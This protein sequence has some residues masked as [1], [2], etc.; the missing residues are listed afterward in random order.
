M[1][2]RSNKDV[3]VG[4]ECQTKKGNALNTINPMEHG[5]VTSW[6]DM[7]HVWHHTFYNELRVDPMEHG[8]LLTEKTMNPKANREKTIQLM[9]ER[10]QVPTTCIMIDAL[11]A[12]YASGR[13]TG[14]AL[15][16]GKSVTHAVPVFEGYALQHAIQRLLVGGDQVE[17]HM[18]RLLFD[19]GGY[20]F[21]T[22]YKAQNYGSLRNIKETLTYVAANFE[23]EAPNPLSYE[24][25]D[26]NTVKD[27]GKERFHCPEVLLDPNA[28]PISPCPGPNAM[29]KPHHSVAHSQGA[30]QPWS[31]C[32][33]QPRHWRA[34]TR[35]QRHHRV[36]CG[37]VAQ[38][39]PQHYG[40]WGQ[41][42]VPWPARPPPGKINPYKAK[43]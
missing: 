36:R 15:D 42:S 38:F 2:D 43:T 6:D 39:V 9:F 28:K 16:V 27:I 14:I 29:L 37:S 22:N 33:G 30:F 10:F 34:Q 12:L 24:L 7:E 40:V 13:T 35:Q 20:T 5:I 31:R 19:L 17:D 18:R 21:P 11:L 25:P 23:T 3:Y 8:V 4:D 41:Q 1:I 26:G 32:Q